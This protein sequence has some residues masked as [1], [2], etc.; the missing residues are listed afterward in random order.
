MLEELFKSCLEDDEIQSDVQELE[1]SAKK[2]QKVARGRAG[3][4][5][6]AEMLDAKIK[7]SAAIKLQKVTRGKSGRRRSFE[8]LDNKLKH[9][10]AVKLQAQARLKIAKMVTAQKMEAKKR[11]DAERVKASI[12]LRAAQ[13]AEIAAKRIKERKMKELEEKKARE[14]KEKQ[15]GLKKAEM[16]SDKM[17]GEYLEDM[18]KEEIDKAMEE[19]REALRKAEQEKSKEEVVAEKGLDDDSIEPPDGFPPLRGQMS[20]PLDDDGEI[21]D[22][23][24]EFG[25]A[26]VVVDNSAQQEVIVQQQHDYDWDAHSHSYLDRLLEHLDFDKRTC[27]GG[28]RPTLRKRASDLC[29]RALF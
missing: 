17:S 5:K 4:R 25:G 29:S 21:D 14:L 10:A 8:L 26:G 19:R 27:R 24:Y 12:E 3:R 9:G 6:S 28:G 22:D 23:L 2:L 1:L 7:D 15:A 16:T 11:E 18:L 20:L 13:E